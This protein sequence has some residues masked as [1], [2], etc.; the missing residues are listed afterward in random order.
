MVTA[1]EEIRTLQRQVSDLKSSAKRLHEKGCRATGEEQY[2]FVAWLFSRLFGLLFFVVFIG[3]YHQIDGLLGSRGLL[4]AYTFLE[5]VRASNP[6]SYEKILPSIFWYTGASD[7]AL[8]NV[9]AAG[10]ILSALIFLG[11]GA[12]APVVFIV[13]ALYM[14]VF[15]VGQTFLTFQWDV[16]LLETGFLTIFLAPVFCPRHYTSP[17]AKPSIVMV[18]LF[19]W[20]LFRFM[21]SSGIVKLNETWTKLTAMN[22]HYYTQP[23]PNPISWYMHHLP[24]WYHKLE[25]WGTFIIELPVPIFVFSERLPRIVMGVIMVIFQVVLIFTGNFNWFNYHTIFICLWVF[26]DRFFGVHTPQDITAPSNNRRSP[27]AFSISDQDRFYTGEL[28]YDRNSDPCAKDTETNRSFAG[29]H[30]EAEES[31]LG[32][33]M[34]LSSNRKSSSSLGTGKRNSPSK[35]ESVEGD[36]SSKVDDVSQTEPSL[37]KTVFHSKTDLF[38]GASIASRRHTKIR[39][40][41][42]TAV[43][44]CVAFVVVTASI[45][46]FSALFFPKEG[47]PQAVADV[48]WKTSSLRIVGSYG[49]FAHMTMK[50]EE[51]II[52]GSNDGV[53]WL[54]YEFKY[55]PGNLSRPPP[56]V[57]PYHPRL[58]WQMWFAAL[59]DY[60]HNPWLV[61]L[62]HRLQQ[63]SAPVLA[64]LHRNPFPDQPPRV[65]RCK[66]YEYQFANK[67]SHTRGHWWEIMLPGRDYL[68]PLVY[69]EP[70]VRTFLERHGAWTGETL[71]NTTTGG[72]SLA[73]Y[74]DF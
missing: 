56:F 6:T 45:Y 47:L 2:A 10:A 8:H 44:L 28:L 37:A 13:W 48:Y 17:N 14:S 60:A 25:V 11:P 35:A 38:N 20:L 74:W 73:T 29:R 39:R 70:T 22:Y 65:I 1:Y 58:D 23:I 54:D 50:R 19:R 41:L 26:D 7:A 40:L 68:P 4:P 5:R 61:H 15:H 12:T 63:G 64:L 66:A 30:L 62:V 53:V 34:V 59:G 71:S 55:K 52:E 31:I 33:R 57:A 46:T 9:C 16:F 32:N 72:L 18:W 49:L 27:N 36:L 67:D 43:S 69:G 3:L 21:I 51:I 24:D 42:R